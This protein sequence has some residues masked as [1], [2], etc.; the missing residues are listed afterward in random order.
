MIMQKHRSNLAKIKSAYP[1]IFQFIRTNKLNENDMESVIAHIN[2]KLQYRNM[3]QDFK[4]PNGVVRPIVTK[5]RAIAYTT[6]VIS[7]RF[8]RNKKANQNR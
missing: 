5:P 2:N 8:R 7:I 4:L 3:Y 1:E 6:F